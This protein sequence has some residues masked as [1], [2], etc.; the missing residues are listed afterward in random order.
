MKDSDN[1]YQEF[2][3]HIEEYRT[4]RAEISELLNESRAIERYVLLGSGAVWAWLVTKNNSNLPLLSW[5][6]PLFFSF[7]GAFRSYALWRAISRAGEY[8]RILEEIL[9]KTDK[10]KGWETWI[11]QSD[12]QAYLLISAKIYWSILL[13]ITFIVPFWLKT[14]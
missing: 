6:I 12:R 2:E 9:L 1:S 7:F 5:W 13:V 8:I 11:S 10:V 3:F 4:L 14:P